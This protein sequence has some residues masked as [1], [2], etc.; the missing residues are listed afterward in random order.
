[1]LVLEGWNETIRLVGAWAGL[2][3]GYGGAFFLQLVPYAAGRSVCAGKRERLGAFKAALLA[4]V[5]R[6]RSA[7]G[8]QC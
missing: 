8:A 5:R 7:F 3:V 4:E 2:C 1:M 6:I